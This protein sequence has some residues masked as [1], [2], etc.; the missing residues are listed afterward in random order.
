MLSLDMEKAFDS[1][2]WKFMAAVL[3]R[4]GFGPKF[5]M[6]ISLLY[7]SPVAAL[8]NVGIFLRA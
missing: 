8:C 1:V 7:S 4:M 5:L 3:G 6:W 2:D